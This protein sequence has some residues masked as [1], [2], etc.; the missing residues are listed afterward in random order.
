MYSAKGRLACF[1]FALQ[2]DVLAVPLIAGHQYH[3]NPWP[4]ADVI[5]RLEQ[6]AASLGAHYPLERL[7]G[8]ITA[9]MAATASDAVASSLVK[10][11]KWSVAG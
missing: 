5:E 9:F 11:V 7:A 1:P 4:R 10:R 2:F 8:H 6:V 3:D